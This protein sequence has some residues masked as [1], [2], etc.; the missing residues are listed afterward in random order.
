[1]FTGRPSP[2]SICSRH[3]EW[4][5]CYLSWLP[6]LSSCLPYRHVPLA[7]PSGPPSVSLSSL[8]PGLT[9]GH[10]SSRPCCPVHTQT[11]LSNAVL[12]AT[13]LCASLPPSSCR[14]CSGSSSGPPGL[15]YPALPH[16][17]AISFPTCLQY[18]QFIPIRPALR[19]VA[20]P[21]SL[22]LSVLHRPS[23]TGT[24]QPAVPAALQGPTRVFP[25]NNPSCPP[26]LGL[27]DQV[28]GKVFNLPSAH[29][30]Q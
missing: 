11:H 18:K 20:D 16:L 21:G 6:R 26:V 4:D 7:H 27:P 12:A 5:A 28:R 30:V 15:S 25:V 10:S 29:D 23:S 1:M 3:F 9:L 14:L 22:M 2:I 17:C 13:G 24:V 19:P 8:W